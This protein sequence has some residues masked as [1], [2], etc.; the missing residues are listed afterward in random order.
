MLSTLSTISATE[1]VKVLS[2]VEY[3]IGSVDGNAHAITLFTNKLWDLILLKLT[4]VVPYKS[5]FQWYE[6][7]NRGYCIPNEKPEKEW[8]IVLSIKT[9]AECL[10]LSTNADDL[11]HLYDRITDAAKV[12]QNISITVTQG[13]ST[14]I[15]GYLDAVGVQEHG[16][17][18]DCVMQSNAIFFF[19]IN[20]QLIAY[21]DTQRPSLYHFNHAWLHFSGNTQNAYAAAKRFGRLYSQNTHNRRIPENAGASMTIGT[22]RKTF[23]EIE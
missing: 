1:T 13:K 16:D 19:F 20:P 14:K 12:L 22:L 5:R 21:L 6:D 8:F 23:A 18:D 7:G 15:D 17:I 2:N 9:I 4:E 10:N 3:R 11:A